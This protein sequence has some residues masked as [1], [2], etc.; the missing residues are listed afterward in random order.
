MKQ[1]ALLWILLAASTS[2]GLPALQPYPGSTAHWGRHIQRTV[3]LLAESTPEHRNTVK[4]LFYG[5]SIVGGKFHAWVERDL[6]E[7]FPHADLVVENKA[8]GGYSSKY[9]I[10]TVERDVIASQPDLVIFKVQGDHILYEKIIHTIRQRTAAEV[11]LLSS[12]WTARDQNPDGSFKMGG[13]AA[14]CDA[15]YPLVAKKYDCELVDV[16]WPWKTY[17][18]ENNLR[19]EDLLMDDGVHLADG[20]RWLMAEL[21]NRQMLYRPSLMTKSSKELVQTVEIAPEQWDNGR[22]AFTISG[23]R[24]DLLRTHAG[25]AACQVLIDGHRPSEVAALTQHTR[26]TSIVEPYEWP[27]IMR[28]GFNKPPA[29]QVGH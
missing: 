29:P 4:I 6:R 28:V 3:G 2:L 5:Q 18:Q 9:L 19:A 26:T 27:E 1:F 24:V 10:K 12:H 21:I 16:R 23:S 13:W 17:L 15:F 8:L 14:F 20:G 25:G 11:M 22:L 7:R